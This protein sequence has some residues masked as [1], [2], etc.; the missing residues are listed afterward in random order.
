MLLSYSIANLLRKGMLVS[1]SQL[2]DSKNDAK[3]L[4]FFMRYE[5]YDSQLFYLSIPVV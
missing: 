4:T 2:H 1:S 5:C 3:W